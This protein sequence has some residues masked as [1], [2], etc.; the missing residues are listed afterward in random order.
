MERA[1]AAATATAGN[2]LH[3]ISIMLRNGRRALSK[4]SLSG[5]RVLTLFVLM[6]F[7]PATYVAY[8]IATI[9]FAR[10]A[11]TQPVSSAII[12]RSRKRSAVGDTRDS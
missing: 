9:P 12:F 11:A 6:V 3:R 4:L 5:R 2:L 7:A 8:C 1:R 10:G